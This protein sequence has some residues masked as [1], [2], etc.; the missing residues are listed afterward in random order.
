MVGVDIYIYIKFKFGLALT[1]NRYL[2]EIRVYFSKE[3]YSGS[4][5]GIRIQITNL[6][7]YVIS[8]VY[9]HSKD[10]AQ[11]KPSTKIL[12]QIVRSADL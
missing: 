8:R 1:A 9:G 10:V 4:H 3:S 12:T 6:P 2:T 7:C 11:D 5:V